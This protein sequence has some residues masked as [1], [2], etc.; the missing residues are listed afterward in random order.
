MSDKANPT[1]MSN[2]QAVSTTLQAL[3]ASEGEA[4]VCRIDK[5]LPL[6]ELAIQWV[7]QIF[8]KKPGSYIITDQIR[9]G[10]NGGSGAGQGKR[11]TT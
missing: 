4:M 1:I 3:S 8:M 9:D 7:F 2:L 5:F 10:R 11:G 6:K